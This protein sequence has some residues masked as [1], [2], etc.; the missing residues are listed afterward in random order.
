MWFKVQIEIQGNYRTFLPFINESYDSL[1][2]ISTL[3]FEVFTTKLYH[4][5]SKKVNEY[6]DS[7]EFVKALR[8]NKIN[9][10]PLNLLHLKKIFLK[11]LAKI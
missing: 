2:D 3:S 8:E 7:E 1:N 5:Y 4:L 6:S 10:I 11:I 9:E